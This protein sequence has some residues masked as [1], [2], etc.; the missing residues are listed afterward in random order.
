[1]NRRP[2]LSTDR[3]AFTLIELLGV[4]SILIILGT[5]TVPAAMAAA[6]RGALNQFVANIERVSAMA[7]GQ[8]KRGPCPIDATNVA[9]FG[10]M[11][12]QEGGDRFIAMLKG[13]KV[14]DAAIDIN[15]LDP[16]KTPILRLPI[17]GSIEILTATGAGVP[18]PLVGRI[19]WF[20]RFGDGAP[21]QLPSDQQAI[22]IGTA[23]QA[24]RPGERSP[25]NGYFNFSL[26]LPALQPSPVCSALIVRVKHAA[27]GSAVAIYRNGIAANA[28]IVLP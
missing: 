11:V 18:E 3:S 2:S 12:V 24:A 21:I 25:D 28:Q 22:G 16:N 5:L 27:I 4:I 14:N 23:G 9:H 19:G 10:V 26:P 8:A 15:P 7:R 13:T 6:Q 17:P 20:Y 1:M